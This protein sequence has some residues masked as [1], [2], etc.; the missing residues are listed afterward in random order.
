MGKFPFDDHNPPPFEMI[1]DFCRDVKLFLS[2]G[3]DYVAVV[4]C[5]A[6]KVFFLFFL[7]FVFLFCFVFCFVLFFVLFCFLFCFFFIYFF[8]F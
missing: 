7:F 4:H 1:E 8:F 3:S 6:G 2:H 5:K